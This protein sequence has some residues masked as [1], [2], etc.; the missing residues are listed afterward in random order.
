MKHR[1]PVHGIEFEVGPNRLPECPE[2]IRD[3]M[4]HQDG[5]SPVGATTTKAIGHSQTRK[6]FGMTLSVS[7]ESANEKQSG[8]SI[9]DCQHR[10]QS[11]PSCA[12]PSLKADVN[13]HASIVAVIRERGKNRVA[14]ISP[15]S[16]LGLPGY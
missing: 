10:A 14:S 16:P 3:R 11:S 13:C 9:P 15:W 4:Q 12:L 2:C 5:I 1:C 7:L 6:F 8:N